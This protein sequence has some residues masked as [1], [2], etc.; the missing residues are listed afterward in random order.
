M[1]I[2]AES[3]SLYLRKSSLPF[4][5]Q[6][7][8]TTPRSNSRDMPRPPSR[9]NS[10]PP[11]PPSSYQAQ[12]PARILYPPQH[13]VPQPSI[14]SVVGPPSAPLP[15]Q[16]VQ[17]RQPQ[18]PTSP[19]EYLAPSS[20]HLTSTASVRMSSPGFD[21]HRSDSRVSS[22]EDIEKSKM[23]RSVQ[24]NHFDPTL[25]YERQRCERALQRYNAACKLDSGLSEQE[26]NV[27]HVSSRCPRAPRAMLE[28]GKVESIALSL[29][30][31]FEDAATALY[32]RLALFD[33]LAKF[34][35]RH[36]RRKQS[37]D[38]ICKAR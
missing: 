5:G 14:T 12:P 15:Q 2:T 1:A 28:Q 29:E 27:E 20:S 31:V 18:Q 35:D 3:K 36:P 37:S 23:L 34:K 13:A 11:H 19:P 26:V 7:I 8:R 4:R 9:G 33:A 38:D 22:Q 16:P 24:Y 17:W 32:R 10:Y 21:H 6:E 25:V 30:R